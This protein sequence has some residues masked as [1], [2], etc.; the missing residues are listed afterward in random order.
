MAVTA[1]Q[2]ESKLREE[3]CP[4]CARWTEH[5]ACSLPPSRSCAVFKALP[6][7]ID[8]VRRTRSQRID[9]YAETLRLRVCAVCPHEDDHG[10]C[11]MRDHIDCALDAYLPMVVDLVERALAEK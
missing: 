7:V 1:Q 11:P 6:E 2:I 8:I 4:R 3:I 5:A 9:P 10:T